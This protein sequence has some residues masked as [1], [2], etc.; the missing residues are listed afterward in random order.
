MIVVV[1]KVE[2]PIGRP[3]PLMYGFS[4]QVAASLPKRAV[5]SGPLVRFDMIGG[6]ITAKCCSVDRMW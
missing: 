3:Q 6:A 5:E 1:N 2:N 4:H